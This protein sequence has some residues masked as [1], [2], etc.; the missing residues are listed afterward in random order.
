MRKILIVDDEENI[1]FSFGSILSDEGFKTIP[2]ETLNEAKARVDTE[3]LDVAI[4]DRLLASDNGMTLNEYINRKQPDCTTILISAFPTFKS[5]SQGYQHNIF[6]YLQKPVKKAIIIN[7]VRAALEK[8]IEKQQAVLLEQQLMQSQKMATMG[9]LSSGIV[10]DFNNLFMVIN[11]YL[12][13]ANRKSARERS[14]ADNL[15][16][17]RKVSQ[18]GKSLS[19][20]FL[21]F[22]KEEDNQ[23]KQIKIQTLIEDVFDLLQVMLPKSIE[24]ISTITQSDDVV[25]INPIQIEQSIVN[26]ALN[27]MQAIENNTGTIDISVEQIRLDPHSM[28]SLNIDQSACVKISIKDSGCGM[29]KAT[30]K[31]IFNPF[32]STRP[33]GIGTGIGLSTTQKTINDHGGAITAFSKP[34]LGSKFYIYLPTIDKRNN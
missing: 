33:R 25:F 19:E 22:I 28:E 20:N 5:A 2:A 4:V 26:L 18:R 13:L 16:T 12:D 15:D 3:K 23:Y 14:I 11:G 34:G 17:I 31:Q 29:T 21:S 27:A 32:F 6:A 24:I 1:R 7:T 10:H 30:L 8:T 9:L